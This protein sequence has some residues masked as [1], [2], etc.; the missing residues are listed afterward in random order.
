MKNGKDTAKTKNKIWLEVKSWII[1]ILIALGL[2]NTIIASY[3]V[4]TGSME[5]TIMTGDL[6]LG[7]QF[8][9]G[10]RTPIWIGIPWTKHGFQIPS[11]RL[12]GFKKPQ[13]GDIVIFR[14]PIDPAL[15]YVKR[16]VAGPGQ[17]VEVRGKLLYVDNQLFNNPKN[18]QFIR[19][20]TY[21]AYWKEPGIFPYN[22]G[23]ADNFGPLYVPAKG[24]TLYFGQY[25]IGYIRNVVEL[26]HKKFYSTGT[27]IY[28]DGQ[29]AGYYIV[30]QDHYFMMGDNRDNSYDSRYWGFVPDNLILG[31]PIICFMSWDK[32][33]PL[34]RLFDKI[35]WNRIGRVVA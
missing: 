11:F 19:S 12:P 15:N 29:E 3:M 24:D 4:P 16:C 9:F 26:A 13:K 14:F 2:K 27:K 35:R 23:N 31:K 28:I 8:V 32:N 17:T 33:V 10:A 20:I 6:L 1:I 30:T 5:N 25:P 21:P 22:S 34:Y 18:S 7:N